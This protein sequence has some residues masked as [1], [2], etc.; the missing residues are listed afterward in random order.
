M[1]ALLVGIE[2]FF[3]RAPEARLKVVVIDLSAVFDPEYTALKALGD[4]E[5]KQRNRGLATWLV[6]LN[7][8]VLKW[9]EITSTQV[10]R[11]RED[12]I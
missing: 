12:A 2:Q 10:T 11:A 9:S 6:G 4:C 3:P 1:I 7:P 5:K 8:R